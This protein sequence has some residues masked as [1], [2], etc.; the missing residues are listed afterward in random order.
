MTVVLCMV[1]CILFV[2]TLITIFPPDKKTTHKTNPK[3]KKPKLKRLRSERIVKGSF[4][5]PKP[6][7]DDFLHPSDAPAT[8][9]KDDQEI[10]ES[11]AALIREETAAV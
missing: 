7:I 5:S 10:K 9:N 6:N 2:P 11:A 8:S 4:I 1:H 3:P